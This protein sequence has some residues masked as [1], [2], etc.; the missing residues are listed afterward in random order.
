M[1]M[2]RQRTLVPHAE[3]D[4]LV[5]TA[6]RRTCVGV[7]LASGTLLRTHQPVA[8]EQ[9]ERFDVVHGWVSES[10][11]DRPDQPESIDLAASLTVTGQML[12]RRAERFLRPILHP[13]NQPILGA[14]G[15]SVPCWTLDGNRPSVAVVLPQS[16]I[17]VTVSHKG[18]TAHFVWNQH[19]V[20]A[21]LEDPAVLARLDWL[22]DSPLSG[23]KLAEAIGFR[24]G[25]LV[26]ALSR[27]RHGHCY[28]VVAGLLPRLSVLS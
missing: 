22:P 3:L 6:S 11:Q 21:P 26:M 24:P 9:L 1:G 20:E 5:L 4:L 13:N 15:P 17:S 16:D 10:Q 12:P 27:P 28:R 2:L 19:W 23:R 25:K 8:G 7:D 14:Q 18:V